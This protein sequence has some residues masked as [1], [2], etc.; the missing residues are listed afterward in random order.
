LIL[1]RRF[2]ISYVPLIAGGIIILL[3]MASPAEA[4][5]KWVNWDVLAIYWG[6]GMLVTSF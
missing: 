2:N 6:Y 5:L 3:G 1:Y 4:F